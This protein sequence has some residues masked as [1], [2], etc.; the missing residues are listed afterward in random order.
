MVGTQYGWV[1]IINPQKRWNEKWNC[2][3]VET[4]CTSCHKIEWTNLN[5]LTRGISKGCRQCS[6]KDRPHLPRWLDRRLT[7][8]KGRC[9][10]PHDPQWASHGGR[11]IEF[12]FSSIMEAGLWILANLPNVER[13]LELDRIDTNGHYEPGNLRFVDRKTNVAN[14]RN[15]VLSHF[16]QRYWPYAQSVVT[17]KLS[18]GM[19]RK[20][21]IH[22]AESAVEHKR[23][24]WRLIEARLQFMTY[25]MPENITVTPY[26][27]A[28]STTAD[29]KEA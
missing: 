23:K 3:Y 17:R 25:E 18:A 13:S 22:D 6:E 26:R 16:E 7:A 19:S 24:A 10:N 15:T 2:C 14:R 8:A 28:S 27:D 11:G 20:E 1:K 9:T 4:E 12:R 21:I 29:T 5:S